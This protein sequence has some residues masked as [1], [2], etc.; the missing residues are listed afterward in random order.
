MDDKKNDLIEIAK[1]KRY[2][3]L[4]E[5]LNR[6]SLSAKEVR[7]LEELQKHFDKKPVDAVIDGTVDLPTLCVYLEKSPRMIRRY[8]RQG[9]PVIRDSSGEIFRFKVCG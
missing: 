7:E 8:V 5:N 4:V 2:I 3:S 6:R 9:M 1:K